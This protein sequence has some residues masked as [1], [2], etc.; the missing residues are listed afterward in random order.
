[1]CRRLMRDGMV[2][3]AVL[4]CG[5]TATAQDQVER[6]D[7]RGFTNAFFQHVV[8]YDDPC[9]I[10]FGSRGSD[11]NYQMHL[12][13]NTDLITFDLAAGE[14]VREIRVGLI[15]FEGGFV[16]DRPTSAVVV[17]ASSGDFVSLHASELG[18]LEEGV[19]D[20]RTIGQLFGEPLGDI[21]SIH[22]QAANEGNS[23][24][25]TE[26]GAYFDTIAVSLICPGDFDGDGSVNTLDV[27]AFLNAWAAG[28]QSAD[29]NGDGSVNTL[30]VLAF[31]NLWAAGC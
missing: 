14:R 21:V 15:D 9:C 2:V 23:V 10:S 6:F 22:L 12:A 31:L 11:D 27:L 20:V 3:G 30:D 24:F 4:A 25:P 16:G 19:A 26:I 29:T 17:R 28:D 1:M 8:E 7:G 5:G 13:P 18:V